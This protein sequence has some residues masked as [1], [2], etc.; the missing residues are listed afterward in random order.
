MLHI[1]GTKVQGNEKVE[2]GKKNKEKLKWRS[3]NSNGANPDFRGDHVFFAGNATS[4]ELSF[5]RCGLS[6]PGLQ[7]FKRA[8]R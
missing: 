1:E 2:K 4:E 8:K 6:I 3:K 5:I 7:S